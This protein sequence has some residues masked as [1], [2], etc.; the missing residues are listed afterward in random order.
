MAEVVSEQD[1]VG[2]SLDVTA[3]VWPEAV[4]YCTVL[5]PAKQTDEQMHLQEKCSWM[6][7]RKVQAIQV[8]PA[9]RGSSK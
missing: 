2:L 4:V 8:L 6:H 7:Q 5:V 3:R 1:V 9:E